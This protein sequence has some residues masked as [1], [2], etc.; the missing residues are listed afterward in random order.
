M[1]KKRKNANVSN[2]VETINSHSE[3]FRVDQDSTVVGSCHGMQA[4]LFFYGCIL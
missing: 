4:E 3:L 1:C 2:I